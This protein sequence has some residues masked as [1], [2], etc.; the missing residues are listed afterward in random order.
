MTENK[1]LLYDKN[2][3]HQR[4]LKNKLE[5][6]QRQIQLWLKR[7]KRLIT[8]LL[9]V[10]IVF[11][12]YLLLYLPQWYMSRDAFNSVN[13]SSIEILNNNIVPDYY[14]LSA[15]RKTQVPTV[16]M[17][18]YDST[19]LKTNILTFAPIQNVF[20]RRLWFPARLQIII[21]E[22]IPILTISPDEKV[23][24]I[25]YFTEGG[26]LIGRDFLPLKS[27]YKT[28]LVLTYGVRGDDYRHW[29]VEKINKI[30]KLGKIVE[31]STK[32]KLN[33][34]DLRIPND[35]YVKV[36]DIN[37]R[38]GNFDDSI[39]ERVKRITT[40]LPQVYALDKKI[41]YI[42]LRWKDANYIKLEE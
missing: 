23:P 8:F 21:Q 30:E 2:Y 14:I 28:F 27:G 32:K 16:P 31:S 3:T 1:N 17:F 20:I 13:S 33:Y 4:M 15:L 26:K 6:R 25:A 19:E 24:P 36:D 40:I 10:M 12:G 5:R 7:L 39:F 37:I 22:R 42:D 18:L 9:L 38:L 41:K 35:V 34:I 11:V 29:S